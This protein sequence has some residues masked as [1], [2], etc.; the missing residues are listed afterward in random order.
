[1][2]YLLQNDLKNLYNGLVDSIWYFS[3]VYKN[4]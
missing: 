3:D 2:M 1:M 4:E